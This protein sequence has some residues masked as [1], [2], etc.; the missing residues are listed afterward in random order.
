MNVEEAIVAFGETALCVECDLCGRAL[1]GPGLDKAIVVAGRVN[2][3]AE[4]QRKGG[5]GVDGQFTES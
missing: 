2:A 5:S 4:C 1:G 3:C